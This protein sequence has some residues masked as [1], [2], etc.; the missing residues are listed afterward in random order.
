[1]CP[2]SVTLD[3]D[4]D[5]DDDDGDGIFLFCNS[6]RWINFSDL[7]I[8]KSHLCSPILYTYYKSAPLLND[9]VGRFV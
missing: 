9:T 4:R 2:S 1:M 3:D 5:D 7:H 8:M 6:H